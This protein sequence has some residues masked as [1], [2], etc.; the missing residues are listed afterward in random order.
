M[1]GPLDASQ[2]GNNENLSSRTLRRSQQ[3]PKK[4]V[5]PDTVVFKASATGIN[6]PVEPLESIPLEEAIQ[7]DAPGWF[8]AIDLELRSLQ[9][10][11]TYSIVTELPE[12][13]VAIGNKWVLR[14]KFDVCGNIVRQKARLVI[15]GYRQVYGLDYTKTFVPVVRYTT[16]IFLLIYA[17]SQGLEVDH[18]DVD[19][20]FLNPYLKEE[21]YMEIP[22]YF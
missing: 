8:K 1:E 14:R 7:E 16:V 12:G 17:I 4:K 9:Q 21:T 18:L 5:F 19:T 20:A 3:V 11:D 2:A 6:G 22:E 13:R 10:T 15:K